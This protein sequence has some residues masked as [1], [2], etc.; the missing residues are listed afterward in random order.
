[1][2]RVKFFLIIIL[3]INLIYSS[4]LRIVTYNINHDIPW[5]EK[6]DNII[7]LFRELNADVICLQE[8]DKKNYA[9]YFADKLKM[10]WNK[11]AWHTGEMTILSKKKILQSLVIDI[12]D[13]YYNAL[14]AVKI[15]PDIWV[16][17]IHL[18]SE[19]CNIDETERIRELN[20]ILNKLDELKA[21]KIIIAGDFN[22]KDTTEISKMLDTHRYIDTHKNKPWQKSTWMPSQN[23][24][25]IDRIHARGEFKLLNGKVI[26]HN[27]IEWLKLTGWPTGDDHRLVFTDLLY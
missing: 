22:S 26:D 18:S 3:S 11:N 27:D 1:M 16:A 17:S 8:V 5:K 2:N 13:S 25:R 7:R 15:E 9:R 23:D 20:F 12:P 14:V 24:E 6:K 10:Y 19:N 4:N 21:D